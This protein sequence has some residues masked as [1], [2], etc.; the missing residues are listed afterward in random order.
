MQC[1]GF[2][3]RPTVHLRTVIHYTGRDFSAVTVTV[4]VKTIQSTLTKVVSKWKMKQYPYLLVLSY[5]AITHSKSTIYKIG[6]D[7]E[8]V[9]IWRWRVFLVFFLIILNKFNIMSLL[10]TLLAF[11]VVIIF[12]TL[13]F[14][15]LK[16]LKYFNKI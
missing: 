15:D 9:Q 11:I 2:I 4:T 8:Y 3:N 1:Q 6:Q 7:V 12:S 10:F 5:R 14:L 16:K 13:R